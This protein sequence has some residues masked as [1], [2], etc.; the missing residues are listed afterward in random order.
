MYTQMDVKRLNP[1]KR[2]LVAAKGSQGGQ[3]RKQSS[4]YIIPRAMPNALTRFSGKPNLQEIKF[5]DVANSD[6]N[7]TVIGSFAP[8]LLNGITQGASQ[9]QRIGNKISMKSIRIRGQIINL[10]TAVQTYARIIIFYDKQCN[11]ATCANADLLSTITSVPTTTVT[12]FSEM[13]L[14]NVERFIILRDM[15][16]TLPSVTNTVGVLSN[17]GFDPGQN[18]SNTSIFDVDMFIKL[19]GLPTLYKGGTLGVG[20]IATGGLF[21]VLLNHQGVAAWTFRN[22]ERLRYYDN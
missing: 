16:M 12:V 14:M 9:T 11:G 19:K 18:P 6:D 4:A 10:L 7:F 17:V 21:M 8:I 13:N 1:S 15:I 5:C 2:S 20:D 3:V 22:T